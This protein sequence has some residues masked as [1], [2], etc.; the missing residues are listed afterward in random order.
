MPNR[1]PC[2]VRNTAVKPS[3]RDGLPPAT[4][5]H[6]VD[7]AISA[8]VT[9][10]VVV[11]PVG[12]VPTFLVVTEGMPPHARRSVALRASIHRRRDPHRHRA[13]RRPL[14]LDALEI[15]LPAF[16]IA[17]GPSPVLNRV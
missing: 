11:D 7:Y 9:L 8:L 17:G 4:T 6:V 3:L 16:R 2:A 5:G 14:L 1:E 12:L 15:S 10:F 13:D